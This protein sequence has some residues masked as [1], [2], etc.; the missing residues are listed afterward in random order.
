MSRDGWPRDQAGTG[1]A[2][3][4]RSRRSALDPERLDQDGLLVALSLVPSSYARNRF[5]ALYRSAEHRAVRRRAS[6]LRGVV[7]D[8][9]WGVA[10]HRAEVGELEP[11]RSG[12]FRLVYSVHALALRRTAI[13][14]PLEVELLRFAIDKAQARARGGLACWRPAL[15]LDRV[16]G[17]AE[18]R[19]GRAERLARVAR[20][21]FDEPAGGGTHR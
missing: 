13:L 21:L 19:S 10:G 9:T 8:L 11:L 5:E 4:G 17:P 14:A 6:L 1:T 15:G 18:E 3:A 16:L 20:R 2:S 7:G 12:R